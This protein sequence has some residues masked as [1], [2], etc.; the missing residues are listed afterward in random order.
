MKHEKRGSDGRYE[1]TGK[2]DRLCVCGHTL[3]VHSAGSPAD[4]LLYSLPEPPSY[5]RDLARQ[6]NQN[7]RCGCQRFRLSRAKDPRPPLPPAPL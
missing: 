4:C 7:V 1:H 2:W 3:G 5:D 6:V